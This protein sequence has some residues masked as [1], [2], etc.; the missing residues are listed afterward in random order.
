VITKIATAEGLSFDRE[1][2]KAATAA[3]VAD[4]KARRAE[5]SSLLLDDAFKLRER[6]W[7]QSVQP[8]S[9]P[10]GPVKVWLDLPPARDASDFMR[11]V[12]GAVK[13]HVDLEKTD[14][15]SGSDAARSMLSALGEALQVAADNIN[16]PAGE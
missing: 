5:L 12:S 7:E 8:I 1:Q 9:T 4:T 13:S 10:K 11:A 2:T 14:S 3:K 16:T 6:L 15:D